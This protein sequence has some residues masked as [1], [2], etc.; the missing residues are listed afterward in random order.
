M[1]TVRNLACIAFSQEAL[2]VHDL[3]HFLYKQF[4]VIISLPTYLNC[5]HDEDFPSKGQL[6]SECPLDV[7][8]F[9]KKQQKNLTSF[10]PRI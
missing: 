4:H 3:S 7:L 1:A 10:C 2:D 5:L 8:H 9:S 6:I